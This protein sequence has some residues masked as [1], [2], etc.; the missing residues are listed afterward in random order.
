MYWLVS[1]YG[2]VGAYLLSGWGPKH[3]PQC[4]ISGVVWMKKG[5]LLLMATRAWFSVWLARKS[6]W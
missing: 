2:S 1:K 3:V 5:L 4:T 6:D